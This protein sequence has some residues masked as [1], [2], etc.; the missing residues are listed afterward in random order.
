M[1]SSDYK[2]FLVETDPQGVVTVSLDVRDRP[3][4]VFDWGVM[5]ELERVVGYLEATNGIR[6]VVFRSHK[7]S[8]FLA[9]ADVHRIAKIDSPE[10][11]RRL[12]TFGQTIF[13]RIEKLAAPTVAA[14]HGPCLGGG[15]EWALACDYRLARDNSST[16]IGLP[17]IKLGLIPA[18]GGTQR[19]PRLVG[20]KAALDMILRGRVFGAAQAKRIGL[21]DEAIPPASWD[22][23]VRRF[24]EE[25]RQQTPD[26]R[27][28]DRRG[29]AKHPD[30]FLGR[31][32]AV[33]YARW[34]TRG[35]QSHYPA[36]SAAIEAVAASG[37][38]RV[39][40]FEV[41]RERFAELIATATCRH[42]IDLFIAREAAR[43]A[44]TWV[45]PSPAVASDQSIRSIGIV[46]AGV[47]GAGIAQLAANRG[48]SV[49]VKEVD[50]EAV[51]SGERRIAELMEVQGKHK[52]WSREAVDEVLGR[53]RV[54][55][56][57]AALDDVDCVVEA[58]VEKESVKREIFRTLGRRLAESAVLTS[59]TSSL[60]IASMAAVTNRPARVAGLHFFNPVYRMDLVEI[61]AAP[62][63][64]AATIAK[65]VA[66]VRALG[67][68]PIVAKD[69]PGIVVNRVLF[70]Y[71]GEA[72]RMVSEGHDTARVDGE[73][74]RFG[75][76][77]GPLELLDQ[78]G[79]DV[80]LHVAGSLRDV[81]PEADA[82]VGPL[83]AMAE[84]DRLGKKSGVGFYHY[85]KGERRSAATLPPG[86]RRRPSSWRETGG[87]EADH[88]FTPD[89]LTPIQRRL[90]YPMLIESV[91]CL[92]LG[93][94]D[95]GWAVDLAMVL[96]TG[97]APHR[98]GPLHMIDAMGRET[99]MNNLARLEAI[100]GG[101]FAA[102]RLLADV[103][104]LGVCNFEPEDKG[105]ESRT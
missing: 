73:L 94:V 43:V 66:L 34:S 60:S 27:A 30:T 51:R 70:P 3:M 14:I 58:A 77:M 81:L 1:A 91:R 41:E 68:T 53:V 71:L 21:V 65:L 24:I 75:M 101:R 47:M 63:T 50:A 64:D 37:D 57:A 62:Q 59:N 8:G 28:T 15:L 7:E 56:D 103:F 36:I 42:L 40:G 105:H 54:T 84:H 26:R 78:V 74:R 96:G 16:R 102:P 32:L 90:V 52:R 2:N 39:D 46:G 80:A 55:D 83:A 33:A 18:W 48:F 61:V 44:K 29:R 38:R 23:D 5:N 22:D 86:V 25:K 79:I 20:T 82:V 92:E 49:V 87:R 97:F 45:D 72:V 67:K 4:N 12:V 69:S 13:A 11:V 35:E 9:G 93:I 10:E 100:H 98:G 31:W 99:F 6:L 85:R 88:G 104:D 89:S 95:H 17:E 19:L 76:P